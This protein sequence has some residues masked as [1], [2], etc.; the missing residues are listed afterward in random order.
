MASGNSPGLHF[1]E[2]VLT[3]AAQEPCEQ[4]GQGCSARRDKHGR[5]YDSEL[6]YKTNR[7]NQQSLILE[8]GWKTTACSG[9]A[10]SMTGAGRGGGKGVGALGHSWEPLLLSPG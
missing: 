8:P 1:G 2:Q 3:G 5:S 6:S 9:R 4:E 7:K 10:G